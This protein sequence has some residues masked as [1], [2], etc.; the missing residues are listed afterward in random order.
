MRG[1][2]VDE[3]EVK[4]PREKFKEIKRKDVNTALQENL[5]KVEETL[6]AERERFLRERIARLEEK[7]RGMEAE[8]EELKEFYEKALKDKKTMM[9][10]RDRLR[11]EN[12]KLRE[13][14]E[15]KKRELEKVH[16]S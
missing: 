6:R 16:E 3:V 2:K 5:P 12:A 1:K 10:E 14:L 13:K 7:L 8:I 9:A 15:G 4:L 11:K